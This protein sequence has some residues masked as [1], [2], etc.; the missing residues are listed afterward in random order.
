MGELGV[1]GGEK[2]KYVCNLGEYNHYPLSRARGI[3]NSLF[4]YIHALSFP[5]SCKINCFGVINCREKKGVIRLKYLRL[6]RKQL[7][8]PHIS[9]HASIIPSFILF[10][11]KCHSLNPSNSPPATPCPPSDSAHGM[12]SRPNAPPSSTQPL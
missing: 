6:R 1:S 9:N 3:N 5:E 10:I 11:P 8:D 4:V 12:P 2:C 7:H